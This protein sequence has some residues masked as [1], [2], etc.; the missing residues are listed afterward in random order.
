MSLRIQDDRSQNEGGHWGADAYF[1]W[2]GGWVSPRTLTCRLQQL[3]YIVEFWTQLSFIH[4]SIQVPRGGGRWIRCFTE[5]SLWQSGNIVIWQ[6]RQKKR[7]CWWWW[8]QARLTSSSML[9]CGKT[10]T[11]KEGGEKRQMSNKEQ[12]K[13]RCWR[14]RWLHWRFISLCILLP[15]LNVHRGNKLARRRKRRKW[16]DATESPPLVSCLPLRGALM[17]M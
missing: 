12:K 10:K 15:P 13:E 7:S 8:P 17:S 9:L 16:L 3:H 1:I 4:P 14:W 2:M 6:W 11:G 5:C